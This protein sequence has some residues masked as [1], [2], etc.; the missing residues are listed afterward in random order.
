VPN[1]WQTRS[2]LLVLYSWASK[3]DY[4]VHA[5]DEESKRL[6]G[7][8]LHRF[9]KQLTEQAVIENIY[10]IAHRMGNRA[11]A[12]G[13]AELVKESSGGQRAHS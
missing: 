10:L 3:A 13:I 4:T 7:P 6:T 1:G 11:L 8:S 9:V 12:G 2:N 5:T